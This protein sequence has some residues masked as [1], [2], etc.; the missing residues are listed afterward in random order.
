MVINLPGDVINKSVAY[1]RG[2][3]LRKPPVEGGGFIQSDD[4][5]EWD[6][7]TNTVVSIGG[8]P[9]DLQRM[10]RVALFHGMITGIDKIVPLIEYR[11]SC[12]PN[13]P[14]VN[15]SPE[16]GIGAK[17]LLTTYFSKQLL[18]NMIQ[19]TTFTAIDTDG[20]DHIS[21]DELRA[22]AFSKYG[23][24]NGVGDMVVNNLFSIADLDGN[25]FIS[26]GELMELSLSAIKGIKFV[27]EGDYRS[28]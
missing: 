14:N 20:D 6:A 16:S 2:F 21:K 12:P 11:E 28:T 26:K 22:M 24:E 1:T 23:K 15:K 8:R 19:S 7:A 4:S 13:D 25:G 17:E 27:A 5:V 3:A 18:F 10:Y 9:L